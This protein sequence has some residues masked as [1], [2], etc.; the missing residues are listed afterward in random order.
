M[1]TFDEL[2]EFSLKIS[3][4]NYFSFRHHSNAMCICFLRSWV[5]QMLKEYNNAANVNNQW[6]LFLYLNGIALNG[7]LQKWPQENLERAGLL[8]EW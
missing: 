6:K 8:K 5:F 1:I 7:F 4:K 2:M 3:Y